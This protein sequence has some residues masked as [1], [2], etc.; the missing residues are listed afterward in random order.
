MLP[1]AERPT[2]GPD[3][4][5]VTPARVELTGERPL[6]RLMMAAAGQGGGW[7]RPDETRRNEQREA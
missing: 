5:L 6:L 4:A 1:R 7:T 2:A 3:E